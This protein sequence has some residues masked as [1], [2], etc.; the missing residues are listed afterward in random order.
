MTAST[1]VMTNPMKRG[2][3][4]HWIPWLFIGGF[5][6][7]FAAN[8][9]L[10]A[11]AVST[12][13]GL[14]TTNAY[15]KGLAYNDTLAAAAAQERLGWQAGFTATSQGE[16]RAELAL[17]LTDRLGNP[18]RRA[19]V[20]AM[21][22]RPVQAGHDLSVRLT[23]QGEGRYRAVV[24]LPLVGQWDVHLVAIARGASFQLTERIN[25]AP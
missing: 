14:E 1:S 21:L 18:I 8:G 4:G 13:T 11:I 6:L 22:L 15:E 5:I 9:I 7:V 2:L 16:R 24:D 23:E 17:T 25:V 12:F 10:I 3:F 20:E 19:E